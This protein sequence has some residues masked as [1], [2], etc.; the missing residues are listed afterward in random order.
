VETF[1]TGRLAAEHL[2]DDDNPYADRNAIRE[3]A[4]SEL[5]ALMTAAGAG[6]G[7]KTP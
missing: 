4:C 5:G 6:G 2:F 1:D 7:A 3:A